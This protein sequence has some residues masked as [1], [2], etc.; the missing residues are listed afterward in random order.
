MKFLIFSSVLF[1]SVTTMNYSQEN[2]VNYKRSSRKSMHKTEVNSNHSQHKANVS[3][4]QKP[5]GRFSIDKKSR[6]IVYKGTLGEGLLTGWTRQAWNGTEWADDLLYTPTYDETDY[7]IEEVWQTWNGSE[8]INSEREIETHD[9]N[10]NW[11]EWTYYDEWD[12]S[13]WV[14]YDRETQSYDENGNWSEWIDYDW[15]GSDWVYNLREIPTNHDGNGNWTELLGYYWSAS[16]WALY[17]RDTQSYDENGNWVEW[18][19]YDW[20]GSEWVN[21]DRETQS[22]DGNGNWV[23]WIDYDPSG[24]EWVYN[25][26]WTQSYDE[27]DNWVEWID[28]YWDDSWINYLKDNATYDENNNLTEVIEQEWNGLVW[29]DSYKYI[30]SYSSSTDVNETLETAT[31]YNLSNNYPNPFNP[32][33]KIEFRTAESGFVSLKVYDVLGKS[34]AILV[35]EIKPAGKYQVNFD[36]RNLPSGVYFYKLESGNFVETRKM[37]LMK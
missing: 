34:I 5:D 28:Y 13:A 31:D 36:A 17:Y 9:A 4:V 12:G 15:S 24:S 14:E 8:W 22:Y 30:N 7:I 37:L 25:E 29:I 16:D 35:N 3:R 23:E 6:V 11:L 10:G 26:K 33:T 21:Y 2:Y 32:S 19:D 1:L 18:I 27:K 20:S